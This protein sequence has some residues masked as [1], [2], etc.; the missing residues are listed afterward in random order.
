MRFTRKNGQGQDKGPFDI[1][2]RVKEIDGYN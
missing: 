2:V 1:Q